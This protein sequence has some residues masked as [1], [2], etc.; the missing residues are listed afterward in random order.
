LRHEIKIGAGKFKPGVYDYTIDFCDSS[1]G[2]NPV[3]NI[4]LKKEMVAM[5]VCEGPAVSWKFT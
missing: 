1:I 2:S 3:L 5:W 4:F